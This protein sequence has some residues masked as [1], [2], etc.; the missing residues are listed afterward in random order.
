LVLYHLYYVFILYM[1][2]GKH[3]R[4]SRCVVWWVCMYTFIVDFSNYIYRDN[5]NEFG[6]AACTIQ[7]TW[8]SLSLNV[9]SSFHHSRTY[10][11]LFHIG[12]CTV[13]ACH[14]VQSFP[15][16]GLQCQDAQIGLEEL[17]SRSQQ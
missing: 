16:C 12:E 10:L 7:G 13:V 14:C 17:G 11:R 3:G 15:C 9:L 8:H 6:G 5:Y 1:V 4:S 2:S